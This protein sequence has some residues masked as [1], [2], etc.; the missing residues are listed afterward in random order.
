MFY[1][2]NYWQ[3]IILLSVL[4]FFILLFAYYLFKISL[5]ENRFL[6]I[7]GI[8]LVQGWNLVLTGFLFF[9]SFKYFRLS[10]KYYERKKLETEIFFKATGVGVFRFFLINSPFR[11]LNKRVYL[12]GRSKDYLKTFIEE[13]KQSETSHLISMI[14]TFSI[15]ILYLKYECWE[16]FIWLTIFSILLNLY[17]ILLQRMNR[18]NTYNKYPNLIDE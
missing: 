1:R 13:T 2:F 3:K 18:F 7:F 17:P 15:Q 12:K 4:Y 16:H 11:Y 9:Q 8:N 6:Y 5:S 10:K 14:C